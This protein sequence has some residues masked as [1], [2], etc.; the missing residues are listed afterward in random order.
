M[1]RLNEGKDYY[2]L[3]KSVIYG[4]SNETETP[5]EDYQTF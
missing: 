3:Q 4:I 1:K 2:E 5:V